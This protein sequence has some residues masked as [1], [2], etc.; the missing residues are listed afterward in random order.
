MLVHAAR[1]AISS[2]ALSVHAASPATCASGKASRTPDA[3]NEQRRLSGFGCSVRRHDQTSVGWTS[4]CVVCT[5]HA[6]GM[7]ESPSRELEFPV[8]KSTAG[9][10]HLSNCSSWVPSQ[11]HC[12]AHHQ[13]L[14]ILILNLVHKGCTRPGRGL[15]VYR[16]ARRCGAQQKTGC[17]HAMHMGKGDA[18]QCQ[19]GTGA[20]A[21]RQVRTVSHRV[22]CCGY[23]NGHIS[24]CKVGLFPAESMSACSCSL[25]SPVT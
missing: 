10:L 6:C 5:R 17:A 20:H 4:A 9:A 14:W 11:A 12:P 1:L 16:R 18:Q 21:E 15:T 13:S 3:V 25:S 2:V 8:K 19:G 22:C 23:W 7:R 24:T